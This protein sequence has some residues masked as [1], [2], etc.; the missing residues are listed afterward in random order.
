VS[1]PKIAAAITGPKL[2]ISAPDARIDELCK[3]R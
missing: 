3:A 1:A 2:V